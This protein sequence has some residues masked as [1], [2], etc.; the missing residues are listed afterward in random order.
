MTQS[1]LKQYGNIDV[2][3][4]LVKIHVLNRENRQQGCGVYNCINSV[5]TC[6][7]HAVTFIRNYLSCNFVIT[8]GSNKGT[9][10]LV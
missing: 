1:F 6:T 3:H 2:H 8:F 4:S 10:P 7:L 9:I 5:A